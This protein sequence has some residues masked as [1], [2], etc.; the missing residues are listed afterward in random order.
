MILTG[1]FGSSRR[2]NA[3]AD[4]PQSS[5]RSPPHVAKSAFDSLCCTFCCGYRLNM[6]VSVLALPSAALLALVLCT[7]A[8]EA[9]VPLNAIRIDALSAAGLILAVV[10]GG[11]LIKRRK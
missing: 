10:A 5:P 2:S 7:A 4:R 11:S 3:H 1:L 8:S 9:G 6:R